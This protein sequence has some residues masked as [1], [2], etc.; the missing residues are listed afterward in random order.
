MNRSIWRAS[1]DAYVVFNRLYT[2]LWSLLKPYYASASVQIAQSEGSS[3]GQGDPDERLAEHIFLAWFTGLE[4]AESA[5]ASLIAAS[6][7]DLRSRLVW[8]GSRVLESNVASEGLS[9]ASEEWE[10][11]ERFWNERVNQ[12]RKTSCRERV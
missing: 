4:D 6:E 3:K 8:F 5:L 2:S 12:D 11:L 10:K 1:W 7:D 9:A